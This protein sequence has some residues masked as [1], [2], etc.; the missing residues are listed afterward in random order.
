[1]MIEERVATRSA[2]PAQRGR[3]VLL[4]ALGDGHARIKMGAGRKARNSH[5]LVYSLRLRT[6]KMSRH[7]HVY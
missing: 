6:K 5:F 3:R 4:L 2:G 1:M 7:A